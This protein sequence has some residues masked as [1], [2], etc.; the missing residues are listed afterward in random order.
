MKINGDVSAIDA[1]VV[2]RYLLQDDAELSPKATAIMEAIEDGEIAVSCDPVILAE[3]VWVLTSLYKFPK[4][5]IASDVE[6]IIKADGFIIPNKDRYINALRI[7]AT[8]DA[9]F[10]DA[11]ACAA[12]LECSDGRLLS[13]DRDLSRIP[14]IRR[15]EKPI[16][17]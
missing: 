3:V 8:S 9:H 14:G 15:L 2:L 1:N 10:G 6:P 12:A 7:Y 11:C 16:S 13:F 4:K 5:K 17:K